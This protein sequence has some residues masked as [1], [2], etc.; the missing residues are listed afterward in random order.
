MTTITHSTTAELDAVLVYFRKPPNDVGVL[1][2][3]VRRPVSDIG[4]AR[5]IGRRR[6]RYNS[7][8]HRRQ[9]VARFGLTPMKWIN[10]EQGK[11]LHLRGIN[12]RVI[13]SGTIST[14]LSINKIRVSG[15]Q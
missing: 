13:Q 5:S 2:S 9:S 8:F 14:S 15:G 3:I 4:R 12:A 7:G 6:T 10:S 11:K 1:E